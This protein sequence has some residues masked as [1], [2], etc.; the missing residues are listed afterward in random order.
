[1]PARTVM[2]QGTASSVGKSV[3]V[4]GL[5]RM[6]RQ[7]GWRVAPFK[8]QNMALNAHVTLDGGE[9]GRAQ[10]VQAEAAGVVA[11]VDM[12]PILLK[13]EGDSRAQV[14]VL[15]K[16]IG[17]MAAAEY[18]AKK[19]EL[20]RIVAESF[21]RLRS[22]YDVVVLEGAGSPAEV[23]LRDRDIVNMHMARM[24]DAPVI[25]VGDI[26]RG[27][28]FAALVGTLELLER[29]DRARVVAFIVNKFRGDLA[30]LRPGLD[31][32]ENRTRV[33]VLGVVPHIAGL[34]IADEDSLGLESRPR[35]RTVKPEELEIAVV[36]LPRISNYDEFESLEHEPGVVLSFADD[37]R[38]VEDADLVIVP[39]SKSTIADLAWLRETGFASVIHERGR[40]RAPVLGICGGCQMLTE[41]IDDPHRVESLTATTVEG[42]GLLAARTYFV[43]VKTTAR[44]VARPAGGGFFAQEVPRDARLEGYEIHMGQIRTNSER[45]AAFE[46]V[47]RNARPHRVADGAIGCGGAVVGTMIHGLFDNDLLRS[48]VL[49][50][51]RRRK[52]APEPPAPASTP[53]KQ[54][55]YD[56]LARIVRESIDPQ[57]FAGIV[58]LS[59]VLQ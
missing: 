3:L 15:G 55:E 2:V 23:N 56:R 44:V 21:E 30:L 4:T 7:D 38:R 17:S 54:L 35:R 50:A 8:A 57:R 29:E 41:H 52:G 40:R 49:R 11:T 24:A 20:L 37:P 13:P 25:L 32:L 48:A 53:T 58:G 33:P 43:S 14:V 27:G 59:A 45:D 28:V 47:E 26:D 42:L 36:H 31:F 18:H 6:L 1:V 34:R 12:N 5:C 51:L 46:I 39:G 16:A 19:P 10:A 9:I 22:D